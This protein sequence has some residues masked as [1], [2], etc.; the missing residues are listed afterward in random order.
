MTIGGV[1]SQLWERDGKQKVVVVW[2]SLPPMLP[3]RYRLIGQCGLIIKRKAPTFLQKPLLSI[4][5]WPKRSIVVT[6]SEWPCCLRSDY[7]WST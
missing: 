1:K 5:S 2:E 7:R 4:Q 6:V 3:T